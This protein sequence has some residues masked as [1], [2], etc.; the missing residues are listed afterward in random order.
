MHI[1]RTVYAEYQNTL[2]SGKAAN[3]DELIDEFVA[4]YEKLGYKIVRSSD[5]HYLENLNEQNGNFFE[6]EEVTAQAVLEQLGKK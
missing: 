3:V 4:K 2:Y 6:L 1:I 5:A